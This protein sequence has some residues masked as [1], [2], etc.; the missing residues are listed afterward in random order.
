MRHIIVK[1]KNAAGDVVAIEEFV[2]PEEVIDDSLVVETKLIRAQRQLLK[3]ERLRNH[4]PL[5]SQALNLDEIQ[6]GQK[7]AVYYIGNDP[8]LHSFHA[9]VAGEPFEDKEGRIVV[10]L[11]KI[12]DNLIVHRSAW[13]MG[14]APY[15]KKYSYTWNAFWCTVADSE[16]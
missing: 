15:S 4:S 11:V 2:L 1:I 16:D 7:I 8:W 3:G 12:G 9:T 5:H 14:L 13:D 6:I 10:P